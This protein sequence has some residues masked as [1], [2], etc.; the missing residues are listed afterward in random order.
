MGLAS[1]ENGTMRKT[2]ILLLAQLVE[3]DLW[4]DRALPRLLHVVEEEEHG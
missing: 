4:V 2:C 1:S 3:E